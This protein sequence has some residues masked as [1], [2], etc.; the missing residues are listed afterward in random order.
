MKPFNSVD[1]SKKYSSGFSSLL[2]RQDSDGDILQ[3]SSG[4][5][6]FVEG[7]V[8]QTLHGY[9]L[10]LSAQTYIFSPRT[11]GVYRI[12]KTTIGEC[13]SRGSET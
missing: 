12:S 2:T 8:I 7:A 11:S 10:I 6:V 3:D 1:H 5:L 13:S 9:V 4:V